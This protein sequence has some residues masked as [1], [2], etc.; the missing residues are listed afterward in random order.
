MA[1]AFSIYGW[2]NLADNRFE[3][4]VPPM[5]MIAADD[6]GAADTTSRLA[7]DL[8]WDPLEVGGLEQ[9][10]RLEHMTLAEPPAASSA[11]GHRVSRPARTY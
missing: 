2:E 6:A 1:K 3:A 5:M 4:P 11:L 9:A 10:L 7:A 8:G